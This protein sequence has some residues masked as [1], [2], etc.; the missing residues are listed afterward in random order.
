[1]TRSK[2]LFLESDLSEIV[3]GLPPEVLNL[4]G[5]RVLLAGGGGFL[6]RYFLA[7]FSHLNNE[8]LKSPCTVCMLDNYRVADPSLIGT[9][10]DWGESFSADICRDP[11]PEGDFDIIIHA[12]GIASPFYYRAYPLETLEVATVGTQR[13]LEYAKQS[14]AK[15]VFFSSSEIYGD[16][17]PIH[18]PTQ[19]NYRGNVSTLGP[20]A[21]Y[22]EGKRVGETYCYIYHDYYGVHTNIVRPFNVYGPGMQKSDYRVM[23]NFAAQIAAGNPLMIYGNGQQTRTFCYIV[24]AMIGFFRVLLRGLPGEVYNIGNPAPEVSMKDLAKTFEIVSPKKVTV[25]ST[26]YPDSYPADEPMRRCPDIR[27]AME[28]LNYRPGVKLEDGVQRFLDW[29]L[30]RYATEDS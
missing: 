19:E 16:P 9:L 15:F 22:D 26:E 28:H 5:K 14:R 25:Q 6:G 18:I 21:C 24:D 10:N 12:A 4:A 17:E 7:I 13:L 8:I 2:A 23:P 27:K 11:M 20:R 3:A 29:A 1:M 30:P